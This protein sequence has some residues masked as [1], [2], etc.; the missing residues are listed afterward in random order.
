[1]I[2]KDNADAHLWWQSRQRIVQVEGYPRFNLVH[3]KGL[4][5]FVSTQKSVALADVLQSDIYGEPFQPGSKPFQSSQLMELLESLQ[6]HF[7]S[8]IIRQSHIARQAPHQISDPRLAA[9]DKLAIGVP[10]AILGKA[11]EQRFR[12]I[13]QRTLRCGQGWIPS[14]R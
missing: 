14:R 1:V 12:C 6:E 7:L 13:L 8:Q 11:N 4:V 5:K 3:M 2:A 9:A 10:L